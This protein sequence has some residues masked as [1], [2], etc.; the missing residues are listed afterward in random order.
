M[1]W[2]KKIIKE[3]LQEFFYK[4]NIIKSNRPPSIFDHRVEVGS[5][6]INKIENDV[7]VLKGKN[8]IWEKD[9]DLTEQFKHET[10]IIK[11]KVY[12]HD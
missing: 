5:S 7:Y 1:Q 4:Q 3:A 11:Q 12:G 8:A 6:W 2:I 10:F 9:E